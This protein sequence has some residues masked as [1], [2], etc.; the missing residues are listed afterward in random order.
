MSKPVQVCTACQFVTL[1][2]YGQNY[3][4]VGNKKPVHLHPNW[5]EVPNPTSAQLEQKLIHTCSQ[6]RHKLYCA[7]KTGKL[8][9]VVPPCLFFKKS[10]LFLLKKCLLRLLGHR[11][12][13]ASN[14]ICDDGCSFILNIIFV[15]SCKN[16]G[17]SEKSQRI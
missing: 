14:I 3:S 16:N 1:I 12:K 7:K 2:I 13:F 15:I 6:L 17:T 9:N 8:G 11:P 4:Q 5:A 10:L